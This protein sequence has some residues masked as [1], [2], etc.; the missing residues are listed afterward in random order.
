LIKG[1]A[2][3]DDEFQASSEDIEI[4]PWDLPYWRGAPKEDK[5]DVTEEVME[6]DVEVVE[7]I[8]VEELEK[9]SP[10]GLRRRIFTRIE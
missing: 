10:R 9:N 6:E 4:K 1:N 7:P 5:K 2:V 8:T 3:D